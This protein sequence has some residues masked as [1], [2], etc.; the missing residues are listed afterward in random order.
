MLSI[1]DWISFLISEKNPNIGIIV[2]FSAFVIAA[3]AAVMSVTN[4]AWVSA[5]GAALVSIALMI[6]YYSNNWL[7]W[8]SCQ[9]SRRITQGYNVRKRERPIKN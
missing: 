9:G 3:F 8:A 7:I 6:F 2:G 5:V 1:S 4:N